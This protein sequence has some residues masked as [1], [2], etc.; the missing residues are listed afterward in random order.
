MAPEIQARRAQ[1]ICVAAGLAIVALVV[2]GRFQP[3]VR[4]CGELPAQSAPMLAF[5]LARSEADLQALFGSPS[6]A[7]RA[8]LIARLDLEN[9]VDVLVLIPLYTVFLICFL[10]GAPGRGARWARAGIALVVAAALA[11]YVED[12]CLL[13]LTPDLDATSAW[14]A[15][16]PFA[17]GVKWIALGAA[18]AI[19]GFLQARG[20]GKLAFRSLAAIACGVAFVAAVAAIAAPASFGQALPNAL[21]ASW[22][23]LLVSAGI[24]LHGS[25]LQRTAGPA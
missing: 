16:L 4:P 11:D 25:R 21:G 6:D 22:S 10:L 5:E 8:T 1:R 17:A 18:T 19:A 23:L 24:E 2:L 20:D 14:L 13:R 3:S 9:R 7:C 15:L 12:A